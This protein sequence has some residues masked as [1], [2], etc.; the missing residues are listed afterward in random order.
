MSKTDYREKCL[1]QKIN[2][3]NI[4]GDSDNLKVHHINGDRDDNRLKNL[5]PLCPKC[6]AK[7]HTKKD[8]GRQY[9][10]LT[11]KLPESSYMDTPSDGE[12]TDGTT[13]RI[14]KDVRDRL[15]TRKVG[16][17]SYSEVIDRLLEDTA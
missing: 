9:D 17:E 12:G 15:R 3:C 5:I 1:K 8:Q 2:T 10:E 11:E 6:H 14:E 16:G 7:V 13:I 4:C